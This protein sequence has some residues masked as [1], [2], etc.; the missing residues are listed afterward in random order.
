MAK[1]LSQVYTIIRGSVGGLTYTANQ[2]QQL[3]V[4]AKTAPVNP[5]TNFQTALRTAFAQASILWPTLSPAQRGD[6]DDYAES[7]NLPGPLGVHT[8]SGRLMFMRNY[9]TAGYF[10]DR[11]PLVAEA[12]ILLAPT[13]PGPFPIALAGLTAPTAVGI[14]MAF[15]ISSSSDDD[16]YAY[17]SISRQFDGSRMRFKGP[18]KS[19]KMQLDTQA[20]PGTISFDF[21]GLELGATYFVK[22]RAYTVENGI[23]L[24][25]DGILRGTALETVV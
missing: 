9:G 19:S 21:L 17:V 10:H 13:V 1:F 7:I 5:V 20:G 12:P 16:W 23:A 15:N 4:K 18:F 14:G 6:W 3:I 8:V 2:H 22:F 11:F 24:S 25:T